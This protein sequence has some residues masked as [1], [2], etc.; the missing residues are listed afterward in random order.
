M[1]TL[2]LTEQ[3]KQQKWN[4]I[5]TVAKNNG[6]SLQIIRKLKQKIILKTQ[7]TKVTPTQTQQKKKWVIF[8]YHIPLIQK[9]TNLLKNADLNIAFRTI[10]MIYKQHRDRLPLNKINSSGIY[11]LKC[12][13]CNNLYV[14]QLNRNKTSRTHK[15][16]ENK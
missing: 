5:L 2:P 14:G 10:N 8:T 7:E 12:K 15:I 3:A 9:V 4:N 6:F 13:I 16:H 11:I 1:I